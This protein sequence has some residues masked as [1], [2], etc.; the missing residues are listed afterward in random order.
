MFG[1]VFKVEKQRNQIDEPQARHE[2]PRR[3]FGLPPQVDWTVDGLFG[4]QQGH[5]RGQSRSHGHAGR[6]AGDEIG[7]GRGALRLA[8]GVRNVAPVDGPGRSKAVQEAADQHKRER[9]Q[10]QAGRVDEI[11]HEAAA[12]GKDERRLVGV[13]G[14]PRVEH[15]RSES[16][17]ELEENRIAKNQ[18]DGR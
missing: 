3:I 18:T 1:R 7:T 17:A 13:T 4:N 6:S 10:G 5:H 15:R 14:P 11:A 16:G 2:P 9:I 8:K 12:R